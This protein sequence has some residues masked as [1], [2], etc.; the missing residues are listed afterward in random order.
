MGG[1]YGVLKMIKEEKRPDALTKVETVDKCWEIFF[2]GVPYRSI[3]N[4]VHL[5]QKV[6]SIDEVHEKLVE[7]F[8]ENYTITEITGFVDDPEDDTVYVSPDRLKDLLE[9]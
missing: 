7:F 6:D 5:N 8:Q 1:I 4:K 3:L 9:D 2:E